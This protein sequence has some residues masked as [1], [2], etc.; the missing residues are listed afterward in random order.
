MTAESAA[1]VREMMNY[2]DR[3]MAE[4]CGDDYQEL[5]L[6]VIRRLPSEDTDD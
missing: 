2:E 6:G 5:R 1:E 3:Q 4:A